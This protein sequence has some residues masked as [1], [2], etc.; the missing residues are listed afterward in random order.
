[1]G[2]DGVDLVSYAARS[3][4]V[5]ARIGAGNGGEANEGDVIDSSVENLTGGAGPDR[6]TAA[7]GSVNVLDGGAGADL[8]VARDGG[9]EADA[10]SCGSGKDRA[11]LDAPDSVALSCERV[12][13]DGRIVRPISPPRVFIGGKR[14]VV[15][16]SRQTALTVQCAAATDRVCV[17][18]LK[19]S[20]RRAAGGPILG[21]RRFRIAPRASS[22]VGVRLT[23][24][25]G[26]QVRRTGRRGLRVW[27]H[28]QVR[29]AAGR[30]RSQV[31][32]V[33]L[34]IAARS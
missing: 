8:L 20:K 13:V 17:G 26:R 15:N 16:A 6:L 4:R 34:R 24:S 19:L 25:A 5:L 7:P 32:R 11:L 14:L 29:D 1:M 27:A 33:R 23:A 2:G 12:A 10:V 3:G 18:T 22:S 9:D 21:S 31:V 28:L 30:H